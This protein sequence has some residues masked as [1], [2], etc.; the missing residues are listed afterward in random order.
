MTDARHDL[1]A[2]AR[3]AGNANS[4]WNLTAAEIAALVRSRQVSARE[5]AVA[6][7]DRLDAVNPA[8]NAVV[9]CDHGEVLAAADVTDARIAAGDDPGPLAGVPVTI[10]VNTDQKG[11]ATT[12]GLC[13]NR[14]LI[15][16]SNSPVVDNLQA[17]GAVI[18][19]R[20][21]TPAFSMR[22]FT[23]NQLHGRTLNPHDA[24]ITPGGSSGGAAAAVAAGIGPIG[25]GND[26]GGSL[27]YPAYSCGVHGLRPTPGRI[28]SFAGSA[29]S[30]TCNRRTADGSSRSNC[31]Q[32]ERPAA[33]A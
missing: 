20:T 4:L 11:H 27:R 26:I 16:G 8:I 6:S 13:S 28:A 17:A 12:N 25:H 10:K 33:C 29:A 30:G 1:D 3:N 32:H 15:A 19:G 9:D 14:D 18:L 21:N 7:L 24:S 5:V 2:S 23:D 22:W 31:A